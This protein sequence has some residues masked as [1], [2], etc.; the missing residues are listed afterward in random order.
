MTSFVKLH[1][2]I[3]PA[4]AFE[5]LSHIH[6]TLFF[7]YPVG[8]IDVLSCP[9]LIFFGIPV[10]SLSNKSFGILHEGSR[11]VW[12]HA[13]FVLIQ[14]IMQVMDTFCKKFGVNMIQT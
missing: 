2:Y 8:S 3:V 9:F 4:M 11:S 6:S 1:F 14:Q 10:D 5:I 12:S 13:E 7:V